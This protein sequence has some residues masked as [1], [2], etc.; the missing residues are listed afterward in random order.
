[1]L[2][3]LRSAL[4]SPA[5]FFQREAADPSLRGPV[6]IVAAVA[7]IGVL[8]SIP[9]MQA[10][11]GSMPEGA[12]SFG[13][14][15]LVIGVVFGMIG[16]FIVWLLYALVFYL[17]SALFDGDGEFRDVFALIGWG[18]APRIVSSIVGGAVVV[19]LVSQG[20]FATPQQVQQFSQSVLTSPLGVFNRVVSLAMTLWSA[21]IWV[22][23]VREARD[24]SK[25]GA[26][27][28][29]GVVVFV[30]IVLGL[31]SSVLVTTGAF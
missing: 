9:V 6:V 17:L 4:V 19:V 29:V 5:S 1:M 22:Y 2:S 13:V 27:I 31:A 21:W 24:L 15:G 25:R 16:P 28:T 12:S 7:V 11:L 30:A 18:F 23:A 8:S 10:T 26:A 14:I 20:E 3:S